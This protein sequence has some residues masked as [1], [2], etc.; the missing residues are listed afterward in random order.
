MVIFLLKSNKY[1]VSVLVYR[2]RKRLN[3]NCLLRK[4][5]AV[6]AVLFCIGVALSAGF[7]SCIVSA[8]SEKDSVEVTVEACGVKGFRPFTVSLR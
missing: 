2:G 1:I 4:C 5:G 8:S 6:A 3:G 7:T